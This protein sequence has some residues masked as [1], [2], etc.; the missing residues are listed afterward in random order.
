MT[1]KQEWNPQELEF[2]EPRHRVTDGTMKRHLMGSIRTSLQML[3]FDLTTV[4]ER[5]IVAEVRVDMLDDVPTRR[6]F[7]S[8][9]RHLGVSAQGISDCWC[10]GLKQAE[11]TI[12]STTQLATQSATMPLSQRYHADCVFENPLLLGQFYTDTMDGRCKSLDGDRFA[13]VFATKELF[14]VVNPMQ[15]KSMAGEGL[16]QFVHYYGRPEAITFDGYR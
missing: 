15:S 8:Q 9:E 4:L 3:E 10:N 12:N 11:N 2:P 6:T 14:A 1:S 5:G 7:V 13:Q 16:C